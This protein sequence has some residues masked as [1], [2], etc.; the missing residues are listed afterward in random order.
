MA[1]GSEIRFGDLQYKRYNLQVAEGTVT[2]TVLRD[3]DAQTEISTPSILIRPLQRG[4][5]RITVRPDGVCE[6][7]VRAGEAEIA[8]PRGSERLHAGQTLEARGDPSD[9]EFQGV[10]GI[11]QDDF[12]RWNAERDRDL[13]R[14]LN[15]S[16]RY[17]SP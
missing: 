17:V 2:F 12:D 1:P 6:I 14:R 4:A 7:T 16:S 5:Y 11:P 13:E 10:A 15:S 8:T 3:S 9:P